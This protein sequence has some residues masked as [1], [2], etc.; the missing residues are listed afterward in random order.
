MF[1]QV[2][3]NN[4]QVL[5][6]E[7]F[8]HGADKLPLLF[9]QFCHCRNLQKLKIDMN[10]ADPLLILPDFFSNQKTIKELNLIGLNTDNGL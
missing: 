7:S 8:L 4:L 5:K 9:K 1:T 10:G 2:Q 6:I 3:L